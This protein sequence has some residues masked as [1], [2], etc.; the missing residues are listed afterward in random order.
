MR[1][2]GEWGKRGGRAGLTSAIS[3]CL[4]SSPFLGVFVRDTAGR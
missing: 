4:A 3:A 2:G 1:W